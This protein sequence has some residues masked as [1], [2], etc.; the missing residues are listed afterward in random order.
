MCVSLCVCRVSGLRGIRLC[1][2]CEMRNVCCF[3]LCVSG[4]SRVLLGT[5]S[6]VS[7]VVFAGKI[8]VSG[9]A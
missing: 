8:I 4:I 2:V 7:K 3:V 1:L 6:V 5:S 9:V